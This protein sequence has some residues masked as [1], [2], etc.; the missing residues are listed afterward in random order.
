MPGAFRASANAL[1]APAARADLSRSSFSRLLFAPTRSRSSPTCD[2]LRRDTLDLFARKR[3]V[4][5]QA[6]T[7]REYARALHRN[8]RACSKP[9]WPRWIGFYAPRTAFESSSRLAVAFKR[10]TIEAI[11]YNPF[12]RRERASCIFACG[13]ARARHDDGIGNQRADPTI[14]RRVSRVRMRRELSRMLHMD[15]LTTAAASLVS[16]SNIKDI[17]RTCVCVRACVRRVI[18]EIMALG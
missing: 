7:R 6:D 13:C 4:C 18:G 15:T 14:G 9:S 12:P 2:S 5:I 8:L 1:N 17:K 16:F 3:I 11:N 10:R